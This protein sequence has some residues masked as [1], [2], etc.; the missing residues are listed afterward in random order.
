MSHALIHR[1]PAALIQASDNDIV[2]ACQAAFA[3]EQDYAHKALIAG[4]LLLEK[5]ASLTRTCHGGKSSIHGRNQHDQGDGFLAWLA[6]KHLAQRTAYRWMDAAERVMRLQLGLDLHQVFEPVIEIAASAEGEAATR[7]PLSAVLTL[8]EAELPERARAL[9]QATFDFMGDR[10]L[11]EAA[12]AALAGDA[13]GKRVTLAG[14][15]RLKGGTNRFDDRKDV[16]KFVGN[17]LRAIT[18]FLVNTKARPG[19]TRRGFAGWRKL[20]A[21]HA[22]AVSAALVECLELWP[23]E[24]LRAVAEKARAELRMEPGARAARNASQ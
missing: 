4:V 11:G 13:E 3:A 8:P 10:T 16:A 22:A 6:S 2:A 7:L 15:G 1:A 21:D 14:T 23:G 5:R 18:S 9:K 19:T 12:R 17:H 24:L 20:P